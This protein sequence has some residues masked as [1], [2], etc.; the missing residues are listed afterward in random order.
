[1]NRIPFRGSVDP[2]M[3][4]TKKAAK[5]YGHFVVAVDHCVCRQMMLAYLRVP[6]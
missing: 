5:G 3:P 6:Y 1:M 4:I 2:S